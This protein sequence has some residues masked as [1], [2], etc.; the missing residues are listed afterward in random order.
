[1]TFFHA[2]VILSVQQKGGF[3]HPPEFRR[4]TTK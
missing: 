1:M 4:K 3:I 2:V